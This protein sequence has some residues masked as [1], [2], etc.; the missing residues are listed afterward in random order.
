M[1]RDLPCKPL[2][3]RMTG[4][5]GGAWAAAL[6]LFL[7]AFG[8]PAQTKRANHWYFGSG[9]GID[10]NTTPP[11]VTAGG[12]LFQLE[13]SSSISNE[14]GQL[15]FYTDGETIFTREHKRMP[16]GTRLLADMSTSQAAL[17]VPQPG[18]TT[19][20]YVFTAPAQGYH[21]YG[22]AAIHYSLV[23]LT[24]N[25]G[26]GDVVA[27]KKNILL[28]NAPVTEKLAATLHSN[29]KDVWVVTSKAFTNEFYAYLVTE[30]G[31]SH[32]P[33]VSSFGTMRPHWQG[34][35]KFSPDGTKL[36]VAQ[37]V[38]DI[39]LLTFDACSGA[40]GPLALIPRAGDIYPQAGFYYGVSFSPD[41]SKL[42]ASTGWLGAVGCAKLYQFNLD[43]PDIAASQVLLYDNAGT[44]Y[45]NPYF[46]GRT[47]LSLAV[48]AIQ[49]GPDG[50]IYVTNWEYP[51]LHVI[52]NPNEAGTKA[53]FER[54]GLALGANGQLGLPNF[55]E[56]YFNPRP[57]SHPV[58]RVDLGADTTLCA[59]QTLSLHLP[60]PGLSYR[61]QDGT[62]S[63]SY[64][65][66][67]AGTYWVEWSTP[68]CTAGRDSIRVSYAL[69]P[70]VDLGAD[71]A[72]CAGQTLA[73]SFD[74]AGLD[75][76]WSDHT[77]GPVLVADRPGT[78]WVAYRTPG[79]NCWQAD[80]I[81]VSLLKCTDGPL[82]P[83]VFTPNGDAYNETF[84]V[85]AVPQVPWRLEVY[86]R[87]GKR[88]V[89]YEHYHND[90]RAEGLANGVYYYLLTSRRDGRRFKGWVHVR[91]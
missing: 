6:V 38:S 66:A 24:L 84:T 31:V 30:Q 23:D 74:H 85:V 42:Y 27:G 55:I 69:L 86:D 89:A 43:A 56:S 62:T 87:W 73:L 71:T 34:Y 63:P 90:W 20:F 60:S 21:S 61:W 51:Y 11:T 16:N 37:T 54:D 17:I 2:T 58:A 41:G 49:I 81:Q 25:N 18:S 26:F 64:T 50:K 39:E 7:L 22:D 8:L 67:R 10:F 76:H 45:P 59:G 78:Y 80:S 33:V 77:S 36:A 15:L 79:T 32:R 12:P 52:H 88:V 47:C 65:I 48:G 46:P 53:N 29:G 68:A 75:F 4:R 13:G 82:I 19:L 57:Q 44:G 5:R 28:L 83:N 1:K 91:R 14:A 72:L 3:R 9:S 35:L 70:D 40:I